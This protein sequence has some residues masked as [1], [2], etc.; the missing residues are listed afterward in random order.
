MR[1]W[2][3]Q[4]LLVMCP[5]WRRVSWRRSVP[6]LGDVAAVA[7]RRIEVPGDVGVDAGEGVRRANVEAA[8]GR[9]YRGETGERL[10]NIFARP[11]TRCGSPPATAARFPVLACYALG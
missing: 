9:G 10:K 2:V 1:R 3:E 4:G 8:R 11:K 7:A 6:G 5:P